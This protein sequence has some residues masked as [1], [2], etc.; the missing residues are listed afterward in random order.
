MA[1]IDADM[2]A[3]MPVVAAQLHPE[4]LKALRRLERD[5]VAGGVLIAPSAAGPT[6]RVNGAVVLWERIAG[7]DDTRWLATDVQELIQRSAPGSSVVGVFAVGREDQAT[8]ATY[9]VAPAAGLRM[10]FV[11]LIVTEGM[12]RW[13]WSDGHTLR[14]EEWD[15]RYGSDR[16]LLALAPPLLAPEEAKPAQRREQRHGGEEKAP[17]RREQR[18][19]PAAGATVAPR[20]TASM[21]LA[22][23]LAFSLGL[24][25]WLVYQLSAVEAE[26]AAAKDDAYK[27]K[28]ELAQL[29]TQQTLSGRSGTANPV[30]LPESTGG[31]GG[32]TATGGG[33]I[34]T[35]GSS[36]SSTAGS[37][38][39][40]AGSSGSA[41]AGSGADQASAYQEIS[42]VVKAKD[43]LSAIVQRYY[44]TTADMQAVMTRN[45]LTSPDKILLGQTLYLPPTAN[46]P[47]AP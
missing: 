25:G 26:L 18:G 38:G 45:H 32:A 4:V 13:T 31:T 17:S 24:A 40:A 46:G 9:L 5:R 39:G 44:G 12:P 3:T 10:P 47:K 33:S 20:A 15:G 42:Y 34:R 36:G 19:G 22:V 14:Q 41:T 27:A 29:R 7:A 1:A 43:T 11:Y 2:P 35:G 37:S 16:V 8:E 30:P 6:L 28:V 23:L 21:L